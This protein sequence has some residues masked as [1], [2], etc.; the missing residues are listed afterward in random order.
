MKRL[1][2]AKLIDCLISNSKNNNNI[3]F[4]HKVSL[5]F[6]ITYFVSKIKNDSIK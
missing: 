5:R 3:F 6:G 1:G 4:A 2:G